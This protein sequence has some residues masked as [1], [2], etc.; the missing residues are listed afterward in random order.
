MARTVPSPDT[1]DLDDLLGGLRA[2][3]EVTRLRV[4]ALC[5]EGD[6]TVGDLTQIPGRASRGCRAI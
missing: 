2:V 4:L 5:A 3:G 6:L 1:G